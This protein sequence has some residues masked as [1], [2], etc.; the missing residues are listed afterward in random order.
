M[1][2]DKDTLP[3]LLAPRQMPDPKVLL[4]DLRDSV[5]NA[6]WYQ[7][8][9]RENEDLRVCW[10]PGQSKDG[11]KHGTP[12]APARPFENAA[13]HRVHLIQELMNERTA[14]RMK[15]VKSAK[16]TIRGRS[17]DDQK[18]AALLKQVVDYH[19]KTEMQGE[20]DDETRYLSNWCQNYGH[21]ILYTG[22]NVE[23]QLEERTISVVTLQQAH[24]AMKVAELQAQLAEGGTAPTPEMEQQTAALA[25]Q[26]V[27]DMLE[28]D[29]GRVALLPLLLM[30]DEDL[31][32]M[33]QR[34]KGEAMRAL[35]KLRRA[36]EATYF[37]PFVKRSCPK[38]EALQPMVDVFYPGETRKLREAR[39][40]ARVR[41]LTM[42]QLLDYAEQE[43]LNPD[44]VGAVQKHPGKCM[45]LTGLSEW[46]LSAGG[47][48]LSARLSNDS[49]V[50]RRHYQIVEVYWRAHTPYGV[51]VLYRTLAHGMVQSCFGKHEVCKHYHGE[52]PFHD[53]REE[54]FDKL[55]LS[56]RGVPELI[57]TAQHAIKA[58]WDARTNR[59]SITT[60]PPMTGPAGSTPP[61]VGPGVYIEQPR[62]GEVDW[63]TPP[64]GDGQSVEIERTVDMRV[65]RL[66]GRIS[67]DVPEAL[68]V[69]HQGMLAEQTL[70]MM[71]RALMM[72]VQLIQ[73]YT[74]DLEGRRITGTDD[75][76]TATRRDI[77]GQFDIE[78]E[79]DARDLSL[80]WVEKKLKFYTDLLIPLDNRGIIDRSEIIRVAAESVDP[81]A[82]QR[83][84]RTG[85]QSDRLETEEENAALSTIFSGGAKPPFVM[86]VNHELRA[87]IMQQDLQASPVRQR[88][89]SS[90]PEIAA[91]WEDR[92]QKHL[93]QVQQQGANKQAGI[94][95]GSDPLRQSPLAQL[96]SGGWQAMMGAAP[97]AQ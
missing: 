65:N 61:A 57:G 96:K 53:L 36:Q 82:A 81:V 12:S 31:E 11:R 64:P 34:G 95:G 92:L 29:A 49:E 18:K 46:V 8:Q 50:N 90:S 35:G 28:T 93:F 13:D 88:V 1:N 94:E 15:A 17:M 55:L 27:L 62:G 51:P 5:T 60:L 41:W 43:S 32:A 2:N 70:E 68:Q 14:V 83:F 39:W 79:W 54:H 69:L 66:Y 45:D 33:G 40:I 16:I 7:Q 25:Q 48:R 91:V 63:L 74:P 59:A 19:L 73:Q 72:T 67:S 58:Q 89:M 3:A 71:R 22:W 80:D 86:G 6:S 37:A 10:W 75:Y 24:A 30:I 77:Q 9:M 87:Q 52:Y 26:A 78:I 76:V 38:W 56:S 21:S 20:M 47:T 84:V 4:A 97:A 44:W 42:A 23:K 85:M